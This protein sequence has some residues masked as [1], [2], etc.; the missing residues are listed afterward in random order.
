M[1]RDIRPILVAAALAGCAAPPL[2][3]GPPPIDI[4]SS[5]RTP[6]ASEPKNAVFGYAILDIDRAVLEQ[7][8]DVGAGSVFKSFGS[9]RVQDL[10][11]RVAVGDVLQVSVFESSAGGGLSGNFVTLPSQRVACTGTIA[12]PFAGEILAAGRTLPE[13]QREIEARLATRAIEPKVIVALMEARGP[14]PG[15]CW[16][17][18]VMTG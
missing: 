6:L 2:A 5:V 1:R 13:I 16:P 3:G 7:A 4:T 10:V 12:V 17:I 8:V 15:E 11:R 14:A 9:R 18:L